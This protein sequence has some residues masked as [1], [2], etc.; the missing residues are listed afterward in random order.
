MFNEIKK[1]DLYSIIFFFTTKYQIALKKG[2]VKYSKDI[3]KTRKF[4]TTEYCRPLN[5]K[6]SPI[7]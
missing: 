2:S 3:K 1:C 4:I 7:L 6:I 5:K